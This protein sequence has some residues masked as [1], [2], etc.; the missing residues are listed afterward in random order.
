M[1][2]HL[3]IP[4]AAEQLGTT[5]KAVR[6]MIASGELPA[7]RPN[8]VFRIPVDALR[9]IGNS[10]ITKPQTIETLFGTEEVKVEKTPSVSRAG[11]FPAPTCWVDISEKWDNPAPNSF[12]FLDVFSGAGGLSLG[13]E[14]AGWKGI[15]A[16]DFYPEAV[17]TYNRNMGHNAILGDIRSVEIKQQLYS[18]I[19]NKLAGKPLTLFAGGFPCQ[20]FSLA[21][22]R[23]V[24]DPRNALYKEMLE[25]VAHT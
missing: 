8:G 4:E 7:Q 15:A 1:P 21:G 6:R 20:G 11:G 24:E 12:S 3:T 18:K 14:M 19:E 25:M 23:V 9:Q 5:Q 16:L 13:L 22:N 10:L 2:P 17:Q